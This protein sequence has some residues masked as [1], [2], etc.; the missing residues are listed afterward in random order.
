MV[1]NPLIRPRNTSKGISLPKSAGIL[2]DHA[3]RKNIA[4]KEGTIEHTP[5]ADN[6]ILNKGFADGEY[7]NITGDSMTG[8]LNITADDCL[9]LTNTAGD[10]SPLLTITDNSN[11]ATRSVY[12]DVQRSLGSG[13]H[14]FYIQQTSGTIGGGTLYRCD[15]GQITGVGTAFHMECAAGSS[16]TSN[17]LQLYHG[18]TDGKV[19]NLIQGRIHHEEWDT[20]GTSG[21]LKNDTDG[22]VTHSNSVDI[23]DDTNLAVSAP[24]VLTGDTLSFNA[25]TDNQIPYTDSAGTNFDYSAEFVYDGTNAAIGTGVH[26]T[27][28]LHLLNDEADTALSGLIVE[29]THADAHT[30]LTLK[31]ANNAQFW[32]IGIHPLDSTGLRF[33]RTGTGTTSGSEYNFY[34]AQATFGVPD[35]RINEKLSHNG[36][37]NTYLTFTTDNIGLVTAGTQALN[38]DSNQLTTLKLAYGNISTDANITNTNITG[39]ATPAQF[40]GFDTNGASN[41]ATPSHAQDHITINSA[42]DY[43]VTF[44]CT[45]SSVWTGAQTA[46]IRIEKNNGATILTSLV[47][48][49]S[50]SAGGSDFGSFTLSGI[51]TIAAN[52]TVEVWIENSVNQDLLLTAAS[53]S[54]VRVG[55]TTPTS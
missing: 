36:D 53:L 5:T 10:T 21:F 27:A 19:L 9:N 1:K 45:L 22:Y 37:A 23:S 54:V 35:I 32:T 50:L 40:V 41:N 43:H 3:I 38:I 8:T 39:A 2:D 31:N 42:G 18:D 4:T 51:E 13:E 49:R 12:I 33:A 34:D 46:T 48:R 47:G 15:A 26:A 11:D 28:K 6:H 24:I 7:V 14:A 17:T 29:T 25:G 30:T 44:S 20:A 55:G 52:D 16:T